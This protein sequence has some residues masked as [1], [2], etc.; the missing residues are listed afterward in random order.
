MTTPII[1]K[2]D[3]KYMPV[4]DKTYYIIFE[5][6]ATKVHITDGIYDAI[7]NNLFSDNIIGVN[8]K[9]LWKRQSMDE[10]YFED[11]GIGSIG[12]VNDNQIIVNS[13]DINGLACYLRPDGNHWLYND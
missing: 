3:S 13:K 6:D 8:I 11:V 1:N 4:V 2:I 9:F 10:I 12:T 7:K 5:N